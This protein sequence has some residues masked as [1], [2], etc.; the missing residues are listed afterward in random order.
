MNM[1]ISRL[2]IELIVAC[3]ENGIIGENQTIPWNVPEDIRHFKEMTTHH[4]IVMGRKTFESLPNKFLSNRIHVIISKIDTPIID[5]DKQ[6]YT[7]NFY[8]SVTL[9]NELV[10]KTKKKVFVIGG[11]QIYDLFFEYCNTYH[12]TYIYRNNEYKSKYE[13]DDD[14]ECNK[15]KHCTIFGQHN[16]LKHNKFFFY[17]TCRS[18]I[19]E[20]RIKPY[21]YQYVTYKRKNN[22]S[23]INNFLSNDCNNHM[24]M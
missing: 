16:E 11:N 5:K 18:E 12:V 15:N 8:D 7:L 23:I 4:I 24:Y 20:S 9:L 6:I 17:E 2:N 19:R 13:Y 21:K 22:V 3:D 10:E 14:Y 1:N